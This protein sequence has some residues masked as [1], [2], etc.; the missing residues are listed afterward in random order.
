M[1]VQPGV[2]KDTQEKSRRGARG[3]PGPGDHRTGYFRACPTSATCAQPQAAGA[4]HDDRPNFAYRLGR[5]RDLS[6]GHDAAHRHLERLYRLVEDGLDVDELLKERLTTLKA[7]R[8]QAK[9]ALE[10]AREQSASPIQIDPALIERF[11]RTLCDNFTAGSVPFRKAYLRSLIDVIEVDDRQI[12][13]KGSKDVLEKAVLARQNR[14]SWCSQTSTRWR[15]R[16]DSN[17]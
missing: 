16:R 17:S 13:I 10:R 2:V 6:R 14:E 8:D 15:A 7:D 9:A 1:E 12:R 11:G 5:V 3:D 4:A